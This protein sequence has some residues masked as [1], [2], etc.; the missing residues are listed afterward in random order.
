MAASGGGEHV[1]VAVENAW[2]SRVTTLDTLGRAVR[3]VAGDLVRTPARAPRPDGRLVGGNAFER[4][5]QL[6]GFAVMG[7]RLARPVRRLRLGR[8]PAE[9]C[10]ELSALGL[11]ERLDRPW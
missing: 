5:A 3:L 10:L 2:A 6:V 9:Q 11:G 8:E 4:A 1:G 7:W